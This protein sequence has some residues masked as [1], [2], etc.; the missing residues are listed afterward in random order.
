MT[1]QRGQIRAADDV[2]TP[3]PEARLHH[4]GKPQLRE[5]ANGRQQ[6]GVGVRKPGAKQ[7]P[8]GQKLVVGGEQRSR[9]IERADTAGR[10]RAEC[11]ESVLDAVQRREHVEPAEGCIA[12]AE[13]GNRLIGCQEAE[14]HSAWRGSGEGEV[15]LGGSLGDDRE[16]HE[17]VVPA[18]TTVRKGS[19]GLL[20]ASSPERDSFDRL[21]P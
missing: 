12:V 21:A 18:A 15:R 11:P 7:E 20:S 6:P 17:I 13:P 9:P 14:L 8:G 16:L 2:S 10:E 1:T 19:H 4:D 5:R 3:T